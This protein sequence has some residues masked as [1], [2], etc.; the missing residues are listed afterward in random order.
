MSFNSPIQVAYLNLMV[1][2]VLLVK[3]G[4]I[5]LLNFRGKQFVGFF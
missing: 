2:S 3:F 4:G 1:V 5:L